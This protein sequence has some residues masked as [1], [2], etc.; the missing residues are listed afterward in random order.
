MASPSD[1]GEV[2]YGGARDVC[3]SAA[4]VGFAASGYVS[5]S[6]RPLML[7][8]IQPYNGCEGRRS[9]DIQPTNSPKVESTA[10]P[11]SSTMRDI[12]AVAIAIAI[13]KGRI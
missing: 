13:V 3:D 6:L 11:I 12:F 2:F 10:S 4:G 9:H 5:L 1:R 7:I 8:Y